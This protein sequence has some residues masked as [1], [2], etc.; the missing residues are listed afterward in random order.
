LAALLAAPVAHRGLW[1]PKGAPENTLAAFEAAVAAGYG[2]ELD[3][4]LSRDDEVMVF[5]DDRLER[6]IGRQGRLADHTAAEL[7][8]LRLRDSREPI[9]TL[10]QVLERVDGAALILIELK[11]L[12]GE[13][14]PLDLAVARLTDAYHGPIAIIGFNPWSHAWWAQNRPDVLRGLDCRAA[15]ALV[16]AIQIG[17]PHFLALSLP[18]LSSAPA[19]EARASG[20]PIVGWTVRSAADALAAADLCD[21]IIFEGLRP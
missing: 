18:M 20:F 21:N 9:P 7:A 3:A 13:E 11:T 1:S 14:G 8:A 4:R 19:R 12:P 17:R 6:L 16:D 5:H 15:D 2:I 10:A